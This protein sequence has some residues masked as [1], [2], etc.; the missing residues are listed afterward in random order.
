[1]STTEPTTNTGAPPGEEPSAA[2]DRVLGDGYASRQEILALDDRQYED[3]RV[4][5]W[6]N[7]TVRV[8]G[9]TGTERDAFE[10]SITRQVGRQARMELHDFRAKFLVKAIVNGAGERLFSDRDVGALGAKNAAA[11]AR[12]FEVAQ[13]LS[14][15]SNEDVEE[16][17]G[18]S[19]G[20]P[21]AESGFGSPASSASP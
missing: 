4:P 3:V 21:N 18:N 13:R 11:I 20:E 10:A 15:M 9:L 2:V 19:S 6:N 16:L 8:K 14:G 7:K 12:L 1:M 5:E 17:T